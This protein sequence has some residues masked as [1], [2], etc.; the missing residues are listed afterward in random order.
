MN[1][2]AQLG[3]RFSDVR[4]HNCHLSTIQSLRDCYQVKRKVKERRRTGQ[5]RMAT[6]VN[7]QLMS[8]VYRPYLHLGYQL[9]PATVSARQIVGLQG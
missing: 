5:L 1:D 7:R 4:Y 9:R 3:V 2:L 6:D 8:I